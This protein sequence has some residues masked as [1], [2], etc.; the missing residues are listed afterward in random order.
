VASRI[1]SR[2][3]IAAYVLQRIAPLFWRPRRDLFF[4]SR[5]VAPPDDVRV[6]TRHGAVR[7]LVYWPPGGVPVEDGRARPV[8]VQIHGGGFYGRFPEQDDHIAAYIAAETG[9]VVVSVDYDVAP[10]V[11]YPVAEEQCY[12]VAAWVAA[13]AQANGWDAQRISVGGESA[14]G[15]LAIN[16]CQLAHATRAFRPRALFAAFAVA[17]VTRSDR[18]SAKRM[19]KIGPWVQRL[20]SATY[21]ADVARRTEPLAS[22]WFDEHLAA[23]LPPTLILTGEDDTLAPEMD[24]LA[25]RLRNAGV[26]VTHRSFA[27]TDHGFT[28]APPVATAREAIA[29]IGAH[30]AAACALGERPI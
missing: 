4:A 25:R 30:V 5:T 6:P 18:T 26:A 8:H 29:L 2:A 3:W 14:G 19:A 20:V 24:E 21:F 7:V 23:A 28:H 9:A 13:T 15:K 10:Q 17:D 27:A 12:D 22:P 11:Q 16:V 1:A